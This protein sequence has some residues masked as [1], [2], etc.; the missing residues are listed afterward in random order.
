MTS[1]KQL[2][3]STKTCQAKY[4]NAALTSCFTCYGETKIRKNERINK[5]ASVF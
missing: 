4:N 3:E 1:I 2:Q 5:I